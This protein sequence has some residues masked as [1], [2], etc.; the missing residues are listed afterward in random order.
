MHYQ[1]LGYLQSGLTSSFIK[2]KHGEEKI[3]YIHPKLKKFPDW[4]YG[5]TVFKNK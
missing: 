1:D 4:T 5:I 3:T 2:R